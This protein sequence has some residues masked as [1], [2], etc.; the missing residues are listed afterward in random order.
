MCTL[1]LAHQPW[2]TDRVP[3]QHRRSHRLTH[4]CS[5]SCLVSGSLVTYAVR[6]TADEPLPEVY[7]LRGTRLNTYC[8]SC[9]L[10]VPG[11][12]QSRML[13]SDLAAAAPVRYGGQG[14]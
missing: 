12:P 1:A 11:S 6:P 2:F 9:D 4:V 14:R 3:P 13:M 5:V 10:E 7:W 8:S